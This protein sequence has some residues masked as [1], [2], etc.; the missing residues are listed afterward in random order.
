MLLVDEEDT[1]EVEDDGDH[2]HL[3]AIEVSLKFVSGLI[4][5]RTMKVHVNIQGVLVVVLID[6]GA[7]HS[8][9][10]NRV[11]EILGLTVIDTG[12]VRV[13]LDNGRKDKTQGT[14]KAVTL[15]L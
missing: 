12:S 9:L 14:C 5:L 2:P 10:S 8:F 4:P 11:I 3:E 15:E 6:S 7:T 13:V 1:V